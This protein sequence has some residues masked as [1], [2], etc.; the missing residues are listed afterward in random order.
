MT[1]AHFPKRVPRLAEAPAE[2]WQFLHSCINALPS[3]IALLDEDGIIL[4]VNTAW[5][6]YAIENG[7]E[8]DRYGVGSSYVDACQPSSGDCS[9]AIET[10]N[11]LRDVMHGR[12][13]EFRLEY[14]CHAPTENRWFVLRVTRF[15]ATG[16]VRLV[17]SHED[18]T[19]RKCAEEALRSAGR[20]KDEFLSVL[21]HELRNPLAPIRHAL[22]IVRFTE[23][24]EE[25]IHSAC[26]IMER[27]IGHMVRLVD[28]LL[29]ASRISRGNIEL[30]KEVVELAAV[31]HDAV[32]A[33]APAIAELRQDLTLTVPSEPILINGDPTRLAQAISNL[34]N[35]ASKYTE[36]EGR[37]YLTV[38][39]EDAEAVIKVKDTGVGI[40]VEQL[41]LV[42]DMFAQFDSVPDRSQTGLG[43]GLTLVKKLVGLHGGTVVAYSAGLGQGCEFVVRLPV[44]RRQVVKPA[45]PVVQSPQ[46][47]SRSIL[48]VDD[49]RDSATSLATFLRLFGNETHTAFDGAEAVE[50]AAV[51]QPDV[52]LL[53]IGMPKMNGYEAARS[54]RAHEWGKRIVLIAVTGWGQDEDRRR[55]HEAGFNWHMVKP[56]DPSALTKLLVSMSPEQTI[57]H[58]TAEV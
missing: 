2:A 7:F 20:R 22:Q 10:V 16:P 51:L 13:S 47:S 39:R 55:S 34:L 37:I 29:D 46:T 40:A 44:E 52:I 14:P 11:G 49:N 41:P 30:R 57:P 36:R 15:S 43:I 25:L 32:E 17:V 31:V 6:R 42:F 35:N 4:A 21:A 9:H 27:Q 48:V 28:D 3:H 12:K 56:V 23:G 58:A 26:E 38:E 1:D 45:E 18:V 54:I 19:E 33:A 53:D 24:N 5:R 50:R 8:D